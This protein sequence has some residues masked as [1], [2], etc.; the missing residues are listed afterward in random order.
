[1]EGYKA[2][3]TSIVEKATENS[4]N[5]APNEEEQNT[6]KEIIRYLILLAYE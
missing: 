6:Y 4:E 5:R 1:M 3:D 2:V